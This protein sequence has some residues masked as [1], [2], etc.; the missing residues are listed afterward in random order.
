[1]NKKNWLIIGVIV[2]VALGIYNR[3]ILLNSPDVEPP[4]RCLIVGDPMGIRL[5]SY[6]PSTA[7]QYYHQQV[8]KCDIL[9][10]KHL[11]RIIQCQLDPTY[12]E[13]CNP[14][15]GCQWVCSM[16]YESLCEWE[17]CVRQLEYLRDQCIIHNLE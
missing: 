9:K 2:L 17:N 3:G 8:R 13:D 12:G 14:I 1:M 5:F 4:R 6:D 11:N 16:L 10:K 7:C 15:F